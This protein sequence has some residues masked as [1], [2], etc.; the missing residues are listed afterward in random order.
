MEQREWVFNFFLKVILRF[1]FSF[2]G[3]DRLRGK[4]LKIL[5]PA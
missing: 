2:L 1:A 3:I 5:M 4:L